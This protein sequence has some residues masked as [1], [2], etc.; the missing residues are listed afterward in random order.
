MVKRIAALVF[1][2]VCTSI[3]WAILGS[4]ILERTYSPLSGEL[5][6][7]VAASWGTAQ[8]QTPPKA[9]Y[10]HEVIHITEGEKGPKKSK[11]TEIVPLALEASK[12]D[13]SLD[14]SHMRKCLRWYR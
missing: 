8:Q 2:F 3:A 7:R 6:S 4:T 9:T 10:E 12:I 5:R 1:I 14:L 11:T 13:V